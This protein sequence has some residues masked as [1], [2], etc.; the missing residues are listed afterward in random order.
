MGGLIALHLALRRPTRVAALALVAPA[1]GFA[2]RFHARL[3]A[4]DRAALAGGGT[5]ALGGGYVTPGADRVAAAFFE[6]AAP[7]ELPGDDGGVQI[8]CPVR[9]LHGALDDVVPVDISR[10]LVRQLAGADVALTEVKDGDHRLSA[11]RDLDL[12]QG[13]VAQLARQLGH[14]AAA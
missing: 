4:A 6:G 14:R 5:V 7:F 13:A 3:S 2:A 1:V 10:A 8:T 12:L 11:P 9:I